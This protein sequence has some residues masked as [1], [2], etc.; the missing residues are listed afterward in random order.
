MPFPDDFEDECLYEKSCWFLHDVLEIDREAHR[1]VGWLDTT[2]IGS[3]VEGQIDWPGHDKHL[4]GAV[5]IQMTGT[6]AN[7][8]AVYCMDL[9]PSSGWV[10]FGTHIK[11]GRFPR[12]GRIGP[13]VIARAEATR[14]RMIRGTWFVDYAFRYEQEDELVYESLQ[15]AAWG[16]SDRAS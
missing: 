7:L 11:N 10:G 1:V 8:H 13:P 5:A 16:R 15:V 12:L 2:R 9:R 6:L 3:L 4:P 14:R